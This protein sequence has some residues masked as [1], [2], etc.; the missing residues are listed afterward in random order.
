MLEWENWTEEGQLPLVVC[1]FIFSCT[2]DRD[3]MENA[4]YVQHVAEGSG[5]ICG[6]LA[7]NHINTRS[8]LPSQAEHCQAQKQLLCA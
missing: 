1:L 6:A 3:P 2:I 4:V 8:A 7:A 5:P